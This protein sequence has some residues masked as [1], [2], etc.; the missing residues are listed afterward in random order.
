MRR[1]EWPWMR[2]VALTLGSSA[3][4]TPTPVAAV[5]VSAPG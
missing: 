3:M 5:L 2:L 4:F 1:L